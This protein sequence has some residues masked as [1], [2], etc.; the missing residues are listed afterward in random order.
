MLGTITHTHKESNYHILYF[1]VNVHRDLITNET[2]LVKLRQIW[3]W[4]AL[5]ST[6]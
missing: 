3:V 6:R 2:Q 4:A 1:I 5:A